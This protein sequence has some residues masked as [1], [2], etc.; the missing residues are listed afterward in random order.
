LP[1]LSNASVSD[2]CVLD[3]CVAVSAHIDAQFQ[4]HVFKVDLG[5]LTLEHC[6][7]IAVDGEVTCLALGAEYT[8]L[9]G[10]RKSSETLLAYASLQQ[11]F[12]GLEL[13]NLTECK[14]CLDSVP[15]PFLVL[16]TPD[17]A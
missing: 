1:G 5:R 11:P 8:V 14:P 7:T 17:V 16:L 4:I 12:H 3:D 9:A 10:I 13:I 15:F 6:Q 2:A